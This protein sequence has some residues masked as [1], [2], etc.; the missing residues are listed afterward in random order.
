MSVLSMRFF[1]QGVWAV[2][3]LQS[4]SNEAEIMESPATTRT[5]KQLVCGK[6]DTGFSLVKFH[7]DVETSYGIFIREFRI[8]DFFCIF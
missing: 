7:S 2:I 6:L 8:R 3:Y 5:E 4:I 1:L